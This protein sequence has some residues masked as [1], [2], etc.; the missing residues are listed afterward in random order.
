MMKLFLDDF[1]SRSHT[2]WKEKTVNSDPKRKFEN[3]KV[4]SE[5]LHNFGGSE[6]PVEE[7]I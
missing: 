5:Q 2:F 4:Y 3:H 1:V 6:F 7:W